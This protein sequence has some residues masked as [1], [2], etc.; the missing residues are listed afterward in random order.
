MMKVLPPF[1]LKY[2]HWENLGVLYRR[3][4]QCEHHSEH[5]HHKLQVFIPFEGSIQARWQTQEAIRGRHQR[6]SI[7]IL[8]GGDACV[9]PSWQPH[10]FWWDCSAEVA[11]FYIEP[12]FLEYAANDLIAGA[13][14]SIVEQYGVR[15][16]MIQQ[17][18]LALRAEFQKGTPTR[19]YIESLMSVLAVHLLRKHSASVPTKQ[20]TSYKLP[21]AKL[22]MVIAYIQDHLEKNLSLEEI[23]GQLGMSSYYFARS[24]KNT[25]GIA[26]HQYL[27]QCRIERA[28]IL[29]AKTQLSITEIAFQVGYTNQSHFSTLFRKH[30]AMTPRNYRTCPP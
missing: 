24:F 16:Q 23:A 21:P 1:H 20:V 8:R 18:G 3:S 10:S 27:V 7:T 12:S 5:A 29:L 11:S 6:Q 17:L 15:D 19:L 22:E 13:L 2:L 30:T 4:E 26:P 28:K 25:L 9:I 14:P